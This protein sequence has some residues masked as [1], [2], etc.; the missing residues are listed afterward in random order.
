MSVI[1][2]T[3]PYT[4]ACAQQTV[5]SDNV[6]IPI[7]GHLKEK[8]S[9]SPTM[10]WNSSSGTSAKAE[11]SVHLQS[12]CLGIP[13]HWD[14]LPYGFVIKTVAHVGHPDAGGIIA[15]HTNG[16]LAVITS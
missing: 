11:V 9:G 6:G 3:V 5:I 4:T 2:H 8:Q 14:R 10:G 7:I 12:V 16:M 13:Q 15:Q 1:P